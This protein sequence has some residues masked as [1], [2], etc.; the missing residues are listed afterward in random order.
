MSEAALT[1]PPTPLPAALTPDPPTPSLPP[2][3]GGAAPSVPDVQPA[4]SATIPNSRQHFEFEK[5]MERRTNPSLARVRQRAELSGIR[6]GGCQAAARI[7]ESS[8]AEPGTSAALANRRIA[9]T[10]RRALAQIE[11]SSLGAHLHA[12]R[13]SRIIWRQG[14]AWSR[15]ERTGLHCRRRA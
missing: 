15:S 12:Y 6:S 4:K 10:N 5:V 7:A 13:R 3:P 1:E 14:R 9:I 2:E 8:V 11:P